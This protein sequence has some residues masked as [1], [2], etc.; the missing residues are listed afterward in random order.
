M[1]G[2]YISFFFFFFLIDIKLFSLANKSLIGPSKKKKK[3]KSRISLL[4]IWD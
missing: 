1:S 2:Y 4:A 3:K